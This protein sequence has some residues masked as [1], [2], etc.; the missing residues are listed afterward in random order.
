M[1]G[2]FFR[3]DS[4]IQFLFLGPE[5]GFLSCGQFTHNCGGKIN[6]HSIFHENYFF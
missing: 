4:M 1:I 6:N 5:L 2:S 3:W